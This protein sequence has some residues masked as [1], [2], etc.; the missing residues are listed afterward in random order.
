MDKRYEIIEDDFPKLLADTVV[1]LHKIPVSYDT[2]VQV[3]S[4][5]M[6][7]EVMYRFADVHVT[8]ET[9]KL[10]INLIYKWSDEL[11]R[12]TGKPWNI[13]KLRITKYEWLYSKI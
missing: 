8:K 12:L 5:A 13:E 6:E 9:D 3:I 10:L 1:A 4:E 2:I 11:S 7:E